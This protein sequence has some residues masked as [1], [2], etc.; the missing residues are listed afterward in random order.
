MHASL[1]A[2][3][4]SSE[5]QL[6]NGVPA[7][8]AAPA[9]PPSVPAAPDALN[10]LAA[11]AGAPSVPATPDALNVP[12]AP[13]ALNVPA[14]A[15]D[16]AGGGVLSAKEEKRKVCDLFCATSTLQVCKFPTACITSLHVLVMLPNRLQLVTKPRFSSHCRCSTLARWLMPLCQP[17][18]QG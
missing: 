16:V 6:D 2:D 4:S 5:P 10:V 17:P 1:Q 3:P 8:P 9:V 14:E 13:D 7:L 18:S 11:P 12:A 15:G